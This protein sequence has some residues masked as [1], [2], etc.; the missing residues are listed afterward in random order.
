MACTSMQEISCSLQ[1]LCHQNSWQIYRK[2]FMQNVILLGWV[3]C[4]AC[5]GPS[6][7][8]VLYDA[9]GVRRSSGSLLCC[10]PTW[11]TNTIFF[12]CEALSIAPCLQYI[13]DIVLVSESSLGFYTFICCRGLLSF[14]QLALVSA[15]WLVLILISSLI[16]IHHQSMCTL[17]CAI[18]K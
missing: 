13:R 12:F 7:I 11:V 2:G 1:H 5:M 8:P 4:W 6:E 15:T 14:K 10:P 17:Q 3:W 18:N 9:P 16:L